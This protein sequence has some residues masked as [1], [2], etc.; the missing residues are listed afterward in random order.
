MQQA[1]GFELAD[2]GPA[3]I[4]VQRQRRGADRR[5][6]SGSRSR[7]RLGDGRD[8]LGHLPHSYCF[9]VG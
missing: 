3:A 7:G 4:E 8:G 5:G 1:L 9:A 6:P 2:V